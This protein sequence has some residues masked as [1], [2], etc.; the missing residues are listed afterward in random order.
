MKIAVTGTSSGFGRFLINSLDNSYGVSLRD[1]IEDIVP[2][3]LPADI[4]INQAYS[5]DTKQ[6]DLFYKVFNLWVDK[7]KTIINIGTSAIFENPNFDPIYV[8]NKKHLN[9]LARTLTMKNEYKRVRVINLNPSTLE[10]NKIFNNSY[11]KLKFTNLLNIINFI[12]NLPQEVEISDL[13][14]RSTQKR[15]QSLM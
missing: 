1:S 2:K 14:I 15:N 10:N 12:I 13:T 4:F 11:N 7:N 8:S 6:S 9:S 5:K 3:I